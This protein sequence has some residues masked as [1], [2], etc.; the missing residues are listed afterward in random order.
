MYRI[1]PFD[2]DLWQA[3]SG[4]FLCWHWALGGIWREVRMPRL[5]APRSHWA[6]TLTRAHMARVTDDLTVACS[7]AIC[8]SLPP[9]VILFFFLQAASCAT[10]VQL[11]AAP[12]SLTWCS[13]Y[14]MC[15]GLQE[16]CRCKRHI[17]P[18]IQEDHSNEF[19]CLSLFQAHR[20]VR[21][22]SFLALGWK[23]SP[24]MRYFTPPCWWS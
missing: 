9:T 10:D 11:T 4:A 5:T 1:C 22:V 16:H 3:P 24:I 7:L 20:I 6:T 15:V 14:K 17:P 19:F 12:S 2:C 13:I 21:H 8:L 18:Y 23:L